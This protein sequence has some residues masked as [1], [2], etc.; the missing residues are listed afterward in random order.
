MND[1]NLRKRIV[2]VSIPCLFIACFLV[3][4]FASKNKVYALKHTLPGQPLASFEFYPVVSDEYG[5]L[6]IDKNKFVEAVKFLRDRPSPKAIADLIYLERSNNIS[7]LLS[8]E[9]KRLYNTLIDQSEY[10]DVRH[11]NEHKD[12]IFLVYKDIVNGIGKTFSNT[13]IEIVLHDTRNPLKSVV[14]IQNPISG[15]RLGDPTTNF[16]LE[17]IKNY[18]LVSTTGTSFISYPLKLKDGRDIKSSTV[19]LFDDRYGLVGFIC[20]NI[21]ISKLIGDK[22]SNDIMM[23]IENF[24]SISANDK[25]DELIENT[26]H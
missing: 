17:L 25:I 14:A 11:A 3:L 23:F 24:V 6:S 15:R 22:S 10:D 8:D 12:K 1:I 13:N 26:R 7:L 5:K 20:I 21:D 19:P 18:S 16:G 4:F 2:L 9:E